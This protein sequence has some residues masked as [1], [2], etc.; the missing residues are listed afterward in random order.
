MNFNRPTPARSRSRLQHFFHD[1]LPSQEGNKDGN[2]TLRTDC[3]QSRWF[4]VYGALIAEV[5]FVSG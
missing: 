4:A 3:R 2:S 5:A 1:F